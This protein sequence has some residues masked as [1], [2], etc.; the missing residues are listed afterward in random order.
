MTEPKPEKLIL[1][2]I[3]KVDQANFNGGISE[4]VFLAKLA[5]ALFEQPSSEN[6]E[7]SHVDLN[8]KTDD[9]SPITNPI[10]MNDQHAVLNWLKSI[11]VEDFLLAFT[12][13][14]FN[15]GEKRFVVNAYYAI[16]ELFIPR[17][18]QNSNQEEHEHNN[19]NQKTS[20]VS[21]QKVEDV[22]GKGFRFSLNKVG[23]DIDSLVLTD[24]KSNY[25]LE[26]VKFENPKL[27]STLWNIWL[28]QWP[29]LLDK[30]TP[31]LM[32]MLA[33]P[34]N[35][36]QLTQAISSRALGELY[37]RNFRSAVGEFLWRLGDAEDRRIR[38]NLGYILS[39][40]L[41]KSPGE[42]DNVYKLLLDW[43]RSNWRM[44][45]AAASACSRIHQY[46]LQKSLELLD[47]VAKT[48]DEKSQLRIS[49]GFFQ[50]AYLETQPFNMV[51]HSIIFIFSTNYVEEVFHLLANW[52]VLDKNKS[53][54]AAVSRE[55]YIDLMLNHFD[56]RKSGLFS[57]EKFRGS[58]TFKSEDVST[59]NSE[60]GNTNEEDGTFNELLPQE[61]S[62][63]SEGDVKLTKEKESEESRNIDNQN[64]AKSEKDNSIETGDMNKVE[65]TFDESDTDSGTENSS[66]E[67]PSEDE[68]DVIT[69][70][71]HVDDPYK[72][73]WNVIQ[74][75]CKANN[76]DY[77][78][79]FTK[80]L[81]DFIVE[82]LR[83]S[84]PGSDV[85]RYFPPTKRKPPY[86]S[87]LQ[88]IRN[89]ILLTREPEFDYISDPLYMVLMEAYTELGKL[90]PF[91]QEKRY[92]FTLKK[93][94]SDPK[95]NLH[96]D[97]F[98][99]EVLNA[100]EHISKN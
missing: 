7:S 37:C 33:N 15:S 72:K 56:L 63:Q 93:W 83:I 74:L 5:D 2:F 43:N 99:K 24:Y 31:A 14:L 65:D 34:E 12:V 87:Q 6:A 88:I 8:S 27:N 9:V 57:D 25:E 61:D 55:L 79:K 91:L 4:N 49:Q 45:W 51:C 73:M 48:T 30:V 46:D 96:D 20:Y 29:D 76:Y 89:W 26:V 39:V 42:F 84:R 81:V 13:S 10:L 75:E 77:C 78:G 23:A 59:K 85:N 22:F 41:K 19:E 60:V 11:P 68:M 36:D 44:R 66:N 17:D 52:R 62:I 67:H 35:I 97:S 100:I 70:I 40:V 53:A 50:E 38:Y 94:F 3:N 90:S 54:L 16:C 64:Q 47:L 32:N 95:D 98:L 28:D 82:T 21:R 58:R 1:N 92:Y 71:L 18:E 69:R 80:L 86:V